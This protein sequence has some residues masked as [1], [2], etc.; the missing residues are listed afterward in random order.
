MYGSN[1]KK[2]VI[3]VIIIIVIVVGAYQFFN[4][5]KEDTKQSLE[6]SKLFIPNNWQVYQ[7]EKFGFKIK[8]PPKWINNEYDDNNILFGTPESRSGGYIWG[9][10]IHEPDELERVIS[11]M[12]RQFDD[13]K[14]TREEVEVNEEIDALL[15]TVTTNQYVGWISKTVY[16]EKYGQL[17]SIGNGAVKNE[18]FELFYKSIEFIN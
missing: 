4:M 7:N 1:I 9:I 13:R 2:T 11:Q 16:F 3:A 15:V 10:S 17:F 6:S 12:G 5:E 18:N 8:Y 14:E